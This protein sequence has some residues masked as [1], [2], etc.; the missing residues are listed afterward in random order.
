VTILRLRLRF[1]CEGFEQRAR[2]LHHRGLIGIETELVAKV[3][4]QTS[5]PGAMVV[6]FR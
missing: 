3:Q 1:L 6:R 5:P 2:Q 4:R